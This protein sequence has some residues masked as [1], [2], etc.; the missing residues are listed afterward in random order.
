MSPR[1][2]PSQGDGRDA[3][4]QLLRDLRAEARRLVP[5]AGG[6]GE[7]GVEAGRVR[8]ACLDDEVVAY[9]ARNRARLR[10]S[11]P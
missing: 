6:F 5:P 8:L 9:D 3:L 4:D 11:Q 10:A 7:Q 2:S 1:K